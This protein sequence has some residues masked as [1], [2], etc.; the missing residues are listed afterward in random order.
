MLWRFLIYYVVGLHKALKI[1]ATARLPWHIVLVP[2]HLAHLRLALGDEHRERAVV[3]QNDEK[4]IARTLGRAGAIDHGDG[5][6]QRL[7]AMLDERVAQLDASLTKL[8]P[9]LRTAPAAELSAIAYADA[10]GALSPAADELL[11]ALG[12][13]QNAR[14]KDAPKRVAK[15]A[16]QGKLSAEKLLGRE[17]KQCA[18][19]LVYLDKRIA[20]AQQLQLRGHAVVR[21]VHELPSPPS[22]PPPAAAPPPPGNT[23]PTPPP[24]PPPSPPQ[25]QHLPSSQEMSQY[26][27]EAKELL[28]ATLDL[29]VDS[30]SKVLVQI[31][32][33]MA[34]QFEWSLATCYYTS[35]ETTVP[36][37]GE[38]LERTLAGTW[39]KGGVTIASGADKATLPL[40][41]VDASGFALTR[42]RLKR[43]VRCECSLCPCTMLAPYVLYVIYQAETFVGS[44]NQAEGPMSVKVT[45]WPWV[46]HLVLLGKH[47]VESEQVTHLAWMDDPY[48]NQ[49]LQRWRDCLTANGTSMVSV[50]VPC[51][52]I[53]GLRDLRYLDDGDME[54]K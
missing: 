28:K 9:S 17:G 52:C 45:E 29:T 13:A 22:P 40:A 16:A 15:A 30:A 44:L 23:A 25:Q 11:V 47:L 46:P 14:R 21:L 7:E 39:G 50:H 10:H 53:D 26:T 27:T 24:P 41:L 49:T 42:T 51:L 2:S 35:D 54:V 43:E 5:T 3:N 18:R 37:S 48:Q 8:Q 1:V 33:G 36:Q 6:L 38:M 20:E 12:R 19:H 32:A 34:D 31:V 4:D